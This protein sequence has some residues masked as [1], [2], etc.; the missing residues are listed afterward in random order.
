MK[1]RFVISV[2][3]ADRA[4]IMRGITSAIT[5]LGA[6]IDDISQTV[7]EGYFSV[8]LTATFDAEKDS[9]QIK[10][11]VEANF[12]PDELSIVVKS[13]EDMPEPVEITGGERYVMVITGPDRPG[14]LK[15]ATGFLADRSINIEDWSCQLDEGKVVYIGEL[16]VPAGIDVRQLQTDLKREMSSMDMYATIRHENIF[17]ATNEVVPIRS[18]LR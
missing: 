18:L 11:A 12:P 7:V 3:V 10:A 16:T 14:I 8:I 5:D 1:N 13:C 2:M 9:D 15:K 4:G 17:R 6:N